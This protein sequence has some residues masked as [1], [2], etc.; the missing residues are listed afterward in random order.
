MTSDLARKSLVHRPCRLRS[1]TTSMAHSVTPPVP[2][3]R[4]KVSRRV[5]QFRGEVMAH[6]STTAPESFL[7]PRCFKCKKADFVALKADDDT[8]I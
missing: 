7:A 6:A 4:P 2:S 3:A 8:V 5:A 1:V